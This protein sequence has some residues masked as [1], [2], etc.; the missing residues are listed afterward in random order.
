MENERFIGIYLRV[1]SNNQSFATQIFDIKKWIKN[2]NI[3]GIKFY[4]DKFTGKTMD[5]PGMSQLITDMY[6]G[7]I[8]TVVCWRLDRLGRTALGIF[9]FFEHLGINKCNLISLKDNLDLSTPIG[10]FNA[11]IAACTAEYESEM[12]TERIKSGQQ[13]VWDKGK[14]WGGSKKGVR[15][16]KVEKVKNQVIQLYNENVPKIQI[17]DRLNIS[18]PTVYSVLSQFEITK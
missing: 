14:R 9:K 3:R 8:S 7:K 13:V 6:E 15:K 18:V 16:E 1:S 12:F 2:E 5:R 11:G 17:A 10:R 4:K